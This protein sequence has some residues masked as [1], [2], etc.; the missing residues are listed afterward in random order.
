MVDERD[1]VARDGDPR[2][3]QWLL[4]AYRAMVPVKD[5]VAY[6]KQHLAGDSDDHWSSLAMQVT[7]E[8]EQGALSAR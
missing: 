1:G 8:Q 6:M 2:A 7:R 3:L 4:A 5:V